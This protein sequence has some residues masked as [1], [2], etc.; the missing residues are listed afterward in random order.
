M[1]SLEVLC[2]IGAASLVIGSWKVM[3]CLV[4][5]AFSRLGLCSPNP[6]VIKDMQLQIRKL[7]DER[8]RLEEQISQLDQRLRN[9]SG[10]SMSSGI[11]LPHDVVYVC[12][13]GSCYHTDPHCGYL[14]DRS[15]HGLKLC[16]LCSKKE[17]KKSF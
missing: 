16:Q 14:K 5:M 9:S 6:G 7:R 4:Y 8:S 15:T 12:S 11:Q 2:W 13:K 1:M 10:M 17:S 3:S